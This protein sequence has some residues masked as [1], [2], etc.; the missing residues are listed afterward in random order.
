MLL[1]RQPGSR[2]SRWAHLLSGTPAIEA[3]ATQEEDAPS[4]RERVERLEAEV[5]IPLPAGHPERA[6]LEAAGAGCPVKRSL[7]PDVVVEEQ[8]HWDGPEA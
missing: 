1:P 6:A 8:Y 3:A 2:E 5:R 4:L 7:H